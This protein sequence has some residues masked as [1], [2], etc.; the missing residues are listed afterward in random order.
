M[1]TLPITLLI[2]LSACTPATDAD[3]ANPGDPE[4]NLGMVTE[5]EHLS[6]TEKNAVS[7]LKSSLKLDPP[8]RAT[9]RCPERQASCKLA[10]SVLIKAQIPFTSNSQGNEVELS[11]DRVVG[12]NCHSGYQDNHSNQ[13]NI[14]HKSFGCAM[15]ANTV[16]M[17]SDKQQFINPGLLDYTDGEKAAQVYDHYLNPPADASGEAGADSGSQTGAVTTATQ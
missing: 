1:R 9:L 2:M 6:L 5:V 15:R 16:Q 13:L 3:Y 17:V 8:S 11:Y 14:N 7:E 4:R 12:M 10:R